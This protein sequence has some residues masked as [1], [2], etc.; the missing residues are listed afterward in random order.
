MEDPRKI[1][2]TEATNQDSHGV[3]KAESAAQALCV[4]VIAVYLGVCNG[5]LIVG[6]NFFSNS[7]AYSWDS[8]S[9]FE[10]PHLDS[11]EG[12]LPYLIVSL[13][14]LAFFSWKPIL[15]WR[16]LRLGMDLGEKEGKG[17][18]KGIAGGKTSLDCCLREEYIF[19]KNIFK[20][21]KKERKRTEK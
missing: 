18:L 12:L 7:F 6:T 21:R 15:F 19:N 2:P 10:L 20:K 4:Y 1:W 16:G 17:M 3:I 14:Y 11:V 13:S 8:F 9:P 5:F